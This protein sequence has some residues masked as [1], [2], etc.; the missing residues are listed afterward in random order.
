MLQWDIPSNWGLIRLGDVAPE[1]SSQVTPKNETNTTFNYWSL[2]AISQGQLEEPQPNYVLGSTI[3]S[4]CVSFTSEHV[5]YAKLRPYLNKVIVPSVNGI[6]STEWVVLAPNPSLLDRKYLS[7]ALRTNTFVQHMT[8][9]SSGARMPRARKD[10][11]F[12]SQIP[13]PF[14]NDPAH[15]LETQKRIV[16]R[17]ETLL[18]EVQSARE[19]QESIEEETNLL[20]D[21]VLNEIFSSRDQWRGEKRLDE[22]VSIEASLVDP[23]EPEYSSLPHI[24][25]ASIESGTGRLL[26][27]HSAAEDGMTSSKYL[28]GPGVVLYSKIRPY[29]RKVTIAD[30]KGVCSADMYPLTVTSEEILPEFLMWSLLSPEFT[31]FINAFSLRARIPKVN[32][33]QLM[34][35]RMRYPDI[36]SQKKIAA[37]I[38][39]WREEVSEMQHAQNENAELLHQTEQSLLAQAFRGEL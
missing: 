21:A 29:L 19:L 23:R 11:L 28:F 27:Y 38:Q 20:V 25:G 33:E 5:L 36:N 35:Y 7:Y 37:Y 34:A 15:S 9:S 18:G 17:L 2:D 12:D 30:F 4:T 26:E 13:I 22:L 24:Y 31:E 32:R 39:N 1:V 6:G 8:E 14:P 10:V 3:S 16:L